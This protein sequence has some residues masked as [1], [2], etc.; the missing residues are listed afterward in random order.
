MGYIPR[1]NDLMDRAG[2]SKRRSSGRVARKTATHPGGRRV[3][4]RFDSDR[5]LITKSNSRRGGGAVLPLDSLEK[6]DRAS[7]KKSRNYTTADNLGDKNIFN[8]C[9]VDHNP[10]TK[11]SLS[12]V[13]N[14]FIRF[15]FVT[16][17]VSSSTISDTRSNAK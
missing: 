14:F 17:R 16:F 2:V 15:S 6:Q 11:E 13:G 10:T 3:S 8:Q 5:Y 7:L 12:G 1:L 4:I 9:H